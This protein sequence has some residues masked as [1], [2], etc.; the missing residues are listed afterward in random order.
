MVT[1]SKQV[2]QLKS[3]MKLLKRTTTPKSISKNNINMSPAKRNRGL[4][5]NSSNTERSSPRLSRAGS[6]NSMREF[7]PAIPGPPSD[8]RATFKKQMLDK[9]IE[10][11]VSGMQLKGM[12]E[13]LIMKKGRLIGER[14]ELQAEREKVV[15]SE[16]QVTGRYDPDAPQYM[17]DRLD[18]INE[19]CRLIDSRAQ[20]IRDK[21]AGMGY[22]NVVQVESLPNSFGYVKK[23]K[24]SEATSIDPQDFGVDNAVNL[25]KS[26]DAVEMEKVSELLLDDIVR[27]RMTDKVQ[28]MNIES[29]DSTI[30]E[31]RQTLLRMKKTAVNAA[32]EYEK[33][34]AD[35]HAK[36]GTLEGQSV[37]AVDVLDGEDMEYVLANEKLMIAEKTGTKWVRGGEIFHRIYEGRYNK[38]DEVESPSS[39]QAPSRSNS[40]IK[41][42]DDGT[43]GSVAISAWGSTPHSYCNRVMSNALPFVESTSVTDSSRRSNWKHDTL[44]PI[45]NGAAA[46]LEQSVCTCQQDQNSVLDGLNRPV[47]QG[48]QRMVTKKRATNDAQVISALGLSSSAVSLSPE[49][50]PL[51]T[52]MGYRY[53][54]MTMGKDVFERL[55][56]T[57]TVASQLKLAGRGGLGPIIGAVPAG[58]TAN[59]LPVSS[60]VSGPAAN[61]PTDILGSFSTRESR[62]AAI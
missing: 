34:I 26:L 49:G 52:I 2:R 48:Q 54:S 7:T 25:L 21:L 45:A 16:A 9:E 55:A 28:S 20:E 51:K 13:D 35:L 31:L 6:A 24:G 56:Q 8:I 43:G 30:L 62:D 39:S 32:K 33:K 47:I 10:Q 41:D 44:C 42:L 50:P 3:V 14:D 22:A 15:A 4:H 53:S 60:G 46:I 19:E 1:S 17:D 18:L 5:S 40:P 59:T 23:R 11:C 12:H 37:A 58:S 57:H 36:L 27:L 29:M 61:N 38:S